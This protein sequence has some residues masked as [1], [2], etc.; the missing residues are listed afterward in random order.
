MEGMSYDMNRKKWIR[1]EGDS[2]AEVAAAWCFGGVVEQQIEWSTGLTYAKHIGPFVQRGGAIPVGNLSPLMVERWLA[3][4]MV[5][6]TDSDEYLARRVVLL[7]TFAR[8]L[9]SRNFRPDDFL[10]GCYLLK[11]EGV[12]LLRGAPD[13]ETATV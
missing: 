10:D 5:K 4:H 13:W 6:A 9:R 12:G 8:W 3:D 7:H 11:P 2:F 1:F